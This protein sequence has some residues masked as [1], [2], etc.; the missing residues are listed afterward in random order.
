M[1]KVLIVY[2]SRTGN[3]EKM[4]RAV[5]EGAKEVGIIT[6]LKEAELV[7]VEDLM[8]ADGIAFGSATSWSEMGGRLK[9]VFENML[10][11]ARDKF[12]GKPFVAFTS[13]GGIEGGK[14]AL[15]RIEYI[16]KYLKMQPVAEGVVSI[17]APGEKEKAACRELGRKL[18]QAAKR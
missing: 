7:K 10:F 11:K 16:A 1:P 12:I 17:S 8:A 6:E 2:F 13:A 5:A 3:T 15:D 9:D 18:T 4:A 14:K